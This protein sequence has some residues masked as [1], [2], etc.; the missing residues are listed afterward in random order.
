VAGIGLG[1]G[2]ATKYTA[3]IVLAPLIAASAMHFLSPRGQRPALLGMALALVLAL[4]FFVLANPY[5][6]IDF[7]DFKAGLVHQSTVSE[8]AAGKLGAPKNGGLAYYLWTFTWGLGWAPSL[9]AVAGAFLLWWRE[10]RL[11]LV[12][13]PALLAFMAFMGTQ[14]RYFGRWL[15]PIF[16]LMC[17]LSAFCV[18]DLARR[19]G[20][21]HRL[22][23]I[24]VG[25]AGAF[26][27]LFQGVAFSAH[28]GVVLSRA[29]TRNEVRDWMVRHIPVG[30]HI[31]V[32]PI[33]P[34]TWVQD[35]GMPLTETPNGNRY[36][37]NDS[38]GYCWVVT[39]YTQEGRAFADPKAVPLAIAY[40]NALAREAKLVYSASPYSPGQGPVA[41]NFDWTFDFYPLAY[42]RPGPQMDVWK[43][44]GGLCSAKARK[45]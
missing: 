2:C 31:V 32:E 29:D 11:I 3:G 39:G 36:Y 10:R 8:D 18:L 30:A 1:L 15:L 34:D 44:S 19:A 40:Y 5:S 20:A 14:G 43:L 13:V 33:V 7:K 27:V 24:A 41:F 22:A 16:P 28:S 42:D 4:A 12:F 6:L 38:P 17:L 9:T 23:A 45:S 26:A 35:P 25:V 37:E 21:W